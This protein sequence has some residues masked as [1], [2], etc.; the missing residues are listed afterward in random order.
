MIR[1][2]RFATLACVL[3][4]FTLCGC[5]QLGLATPKG[6]DQQLANA[7]GIHT[8]VVSATATAVTAGSISSAD[9]TQVQTMAS[10][11][12]TLLDT[13]KAAE[14][15]GDAAGAQRNLTLALS[16][17]TALQSYLNTHGSK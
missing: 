2:T 16:A 12:R 10:T 9:A 14:G 11:S 13:A 1:Q 5:A 7:Y 4:L 17:L 15:A 3:T 8:A 6:F